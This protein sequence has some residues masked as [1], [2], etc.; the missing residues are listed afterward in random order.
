MGRMLRY[1]KPRD[2]NVLA[3]TETIR[4]STSGDLFLD[5]QLGD[6]WKAFYH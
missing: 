1:E 4:I 2:P 3:A 5:W 6:V